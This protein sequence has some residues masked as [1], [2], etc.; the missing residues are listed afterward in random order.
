MAK[1]KSS[2]TPAVRFLREHGVNFSEHPYNYEERGGTRVSSRELGM[3]EH[4]V[5]KTLVFTDHKGEI[6]LV[7]MHGDQEVSA[8][9][10]AR[11]RG[12]KTCRPADPKTANRLTGYQVGGISPF[13][14]RRSLA[15]LAEETL[16][17]LD[18]IVINGGKRG[19]LVGLAPSELERVLDCQK[20]QVGRP[21]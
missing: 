16:F 13:G 2:V 19:F 4:Q 18:R 8:K 5:I 3:P 17:G 1:K 11:L 6:F 21:A 10:L 9:E 14:T 20:V 7:L 12:V 15:I